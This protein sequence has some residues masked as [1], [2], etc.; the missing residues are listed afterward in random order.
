M[1]LFEKD[2]LT[3]ADLKAFQGSDTASQT[4][5]LSASST[6]LAFH[7][8]LVKSEALLNNKLTLLDEAVRLKVQEFQTRL[9]QFDQRFTNAWKVIG[10]LQ[11]MENELAEW[12]SKIAEISAT[13]QKLE[14]WKN[15]E[16]ASVQALRAQAHELRLKAIAYEE[17][18]SEWESLTEKIRELS[19]WKREADTTLRT[20]QMKLRE[21]T[22]VATATAPT[23]SAPLPP[24]LPPLQSIPEKALPQQLNRCFYSVVLGRDSKDVDW[25]SPFT[26]LPGWD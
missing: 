19:H 12:T 16:I 2:G 10:T 22:R 3:R 8:D 24:S 1:A 15:D 21:P 13:I 6:P 18:K 5:N 20:I 7:D 23:L 14:T 9:D 26:P 4:T 11:Q 25:V 17:Q